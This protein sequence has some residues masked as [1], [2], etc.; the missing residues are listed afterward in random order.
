MRFGTDVDKIRQTC[1]NI[2][3]ILRKDPLD[4]KRWICLLL[5]LLM[6]A[7]TGAVCACSKEEAP[8]DEFVLKAVVQRVGE[9][10]EVDV[11]ESDYASGLYWVITSKETDFYDAEGECIEAA[12]IKEGDTVLIRYGG[13]VMMSYPPQIVAHSVTLAK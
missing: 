3:D 8:G 4:M 6:L 7:L 1:Y 10:L 12:D 2:H 11:I 9:T 13:Q 5:T